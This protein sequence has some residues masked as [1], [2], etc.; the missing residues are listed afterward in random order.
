[1]FTWLFIF[2]GKLQTRRWCVFLCCV[3]DINLLKKTKKQPCL[4]FFCITMQ[5]SFKGHSVGCSAKD[6]HRSLWGKH[7]HRVRD[8][9]QQA[10]RAHNGCTVCARAKSVP[11]QPMRPCWSIAYNKKRMSRT[12]GFAKLIAF[13]N[14]TSTQYELL[15]KFWVIFEIFSFI[16][17]EDKC[18]VTKEEMKAY[19][20]CFQDQAVEFK[21]ENA[22]KTDIYV[23]ILQRWTFS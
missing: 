3:C 23:V 5:D 10:Q 1:M 13:Q 15:S 19:S 11:L 12:I 16:L 22:T 17:L 20:S 21:K 7:N 8:E 2:P 14:M 9:N 18:Q 4:R 6:M